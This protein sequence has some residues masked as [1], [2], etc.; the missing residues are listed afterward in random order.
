V[1][2]GSP[3]TVIAIVA[4]LRGMRARSG[5]HFPSRAPITT[6]G[7]QFGRIDECLETVLRRAQ[8]GIDIQVPGD[9]H[10]F[11]PFG[12][13]LSADHAGDVGFELRRLVDPCFDVLW[14]VARI[15]VGYENVDRPR[16]RLVDLDVQNPL[17]GEGIRR[18]KNAPRTGLVPLRR[19]P[20]QWESGHEYEPS[21]LG[22]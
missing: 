7:R 5:A 9:D 6:K 4:A 17:V 8:N 22:G 12:G 11:V 20:Q 19:L 18:P 21:I 3:L 2:A 15:H 10:R 13:G 14:I 1:G 16:A